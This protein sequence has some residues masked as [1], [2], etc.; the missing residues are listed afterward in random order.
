MSHGAETVA[1][2]EEK[3][4]THSVSHTHT[5]SLIRLLLSRDDTQ[6]IHTHLNKAPKWCKELVLP[7]SLVPLF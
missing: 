7:L 5:R 2:T 6:C 4:P 1:V 3:D